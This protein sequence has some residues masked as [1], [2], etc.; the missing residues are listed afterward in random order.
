MVQLRPVFNGMA[1]EGDLQLA[2]EPLDHFI[3]GGMPCSSTGERC[4]GD[5]SQ[6]L[7]KA[8]LKLPALVVCNLLGAAEMSNPD[9][10]KGLSDRFG[11]DV[12]H[13]ECLRPKCVSVDGGNLLPEAGRYR[14][15]PD[16]V[17]MHMRE[18]CRRKVE[19]PDRGLHMPR[20]LGPLGGCTSASPSA[21][22]FTHSRP[23][24]PL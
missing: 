19:T 6:I 11:G 10:D 3:G 24:K 8:G 21:A 18:T 5:G 17:D 7:E 15:R 13:T 4:T 22:V 1:Y 14:Q 9:R 20:Y 2:V 23:H 12:K 16:Q